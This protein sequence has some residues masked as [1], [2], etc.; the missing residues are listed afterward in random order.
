MSACWCMSLFVCVVVCCLWSASAYVCLFI[1]NGFVDLCVCFY[2][3][4]FVCAFVCLFVCSCFVMCVRVYV[5][6]VG[7]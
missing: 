6:V 7:C 4:L 1:M 5:G 2:V 3:R